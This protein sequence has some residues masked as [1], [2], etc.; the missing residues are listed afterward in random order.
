MTKSIEIVIG[1]TG[2]IRVEALG[3]QGPDCEKATR[4]IEQALGNIQHRHKKPE[5]HSAARRTRQ[6]EVGP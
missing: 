6:Q 3:F 2:D 1:P 4:F 5:F